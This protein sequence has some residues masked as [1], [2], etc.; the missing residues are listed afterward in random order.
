M[1]DEFLSARSAK[2]I[3][4]QLV[5]V[6][7]GLTI[8]WSAFAEQGAAGKPGEVKPPRTAYEEY[9][10][11]KW[12]DDFDTA[13]HVQRQD[14]DV[15]DGDDVMMQADSPPVLPPERPLLVAALSS[16]AERDPRVTRQGKEED[17]V[18]FECPPPPREQPLFLCEAAACESDKECA[19]ER[20]V[21][22]CHNGCL[23]TCMA[24]VQPAPYI[25]WKGQ[26]QRRLPSGPSWLIQGQDKRPEVDWC[27]TSEVYYVDEEPLLCPHGQICHIDDLG[28]PSKG[29]PNRGRCI[30]TQQSSASRSSYRVVT[31]S[32]N[33]DCFIGTTHYSNQSTFRYNKHKCECLEGSVL[34][35][36][37]RKR[38]RKKSTRT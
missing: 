23:Y 21:M 6:L 29:V 25:D 33:I 5:T 27:S 36:V 13:L 11:E 37:G 20:G 7:L 10:R 19:A 26:P 24:A 3:N 38:N 31:N 34:C 30:D 4:G 12:L 1:Y 14:S 15:T 35:K 2:R 28:D 22:C 17:S 18:E 32:T 8:H 16:A 9:G